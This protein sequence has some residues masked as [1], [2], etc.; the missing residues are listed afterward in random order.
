MPGVG[1]EYRGCIK[2]FK[3]VLSEYKIFLPYFGEGYENCLDNDAQKLFFSNILYF[4][5]LQN[6]LKDLMN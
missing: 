2:V 5:A 6:I 4:C 1:V 3:P